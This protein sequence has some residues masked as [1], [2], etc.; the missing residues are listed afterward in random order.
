MRRLL[1]VAALALAGLAACAPVD[2]AGTVALLLP[3]S[4]TSRYEAID[5]P[6]FEAAVAQ[7]CPDC[8][9]LYANAGQ[10]AAVQQQQAES[11]LTQGA[12]VLVISAVDAAAAQG[13][14]VAAHDRGARVIAYDRFIAGAPVDH[15]VSYDAV[16]VG[17]IQGRALVEA[18]GPDLAPGEGILLVQ[19]AATDPNAIDLNIGF[20]E[21]L[22]DV[23]LPVL[24]AYEVPDWSPDKARDWVESQ[25][26]RYGEQVVGV[27]AA[28]DG[29]ASGA[30]SAMRAAGLDPVPPVTGQDAELAGVQRVVSGDQLMTVYKG[31]AQQAQIAA[32][33]AVDLLEGRA[34]AAPQEIGGVPAVLLQPV[35]VARE[36]V[37]D[38]IVRGGVYP[39]SE[40]CTEPYRLACLEL[41]LIE[42]DG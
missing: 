27:F 19:G 20:A 17:R 5:R 3:E 14:V 30:I 1:L 39:V 26:A 38:V 7:L 6:V 23:D 40:I 24:A 42:E 16:E 32:R 8:R 31:I 13:I 22:A 21:V 12:D 36:D 33:A 37:E 41:G 11:A 35:A 28:N 18:V 25:L 10:D 15:L 29:V 9:V 4:K 34:P 2:D